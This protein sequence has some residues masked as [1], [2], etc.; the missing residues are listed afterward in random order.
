LYFYHL[1]CN[2]NISIFYF[3]LLTYNHS[4]M[5]DFLKKLIQAETTAEKGELAAAE[6]IS[7]EFGLSGINSRIDSWDQIRANIITRI[8]STGQRAGL[9]FACHLDVVGPGEAV[10]EH[11]AFSAV[12]TDGN[13]YGRGTVDMKG[14]TAAAVTAIRQIVDSGVQLKGDVVL[15]AV[16][17]EE[18]DSAGARRFVDDKDLMQELAPVG[19]AGVIIP[20][21]TD[22]EVITAH[23]GILWLQISTKG[24]AAHSSA[25]QLGVNAIG[26]MRLVLNELESYEIK[27]EPHEL[28]GMCS[29]SVNTI[30][31]GKAMNVVPDKC[32]VGI[33]FRTLPRQNHDQIVADLQGIFERLK[34]GDE[35]F[36]A[37]ISILR[38]VRPLETDVNSEFVK[39]FGSAVGINETKAINYTTDGP[40]FASIGAPIVIFGPGKPQ[41]CHKPD[42]Y[43]EISDLDKA[44]EYYKNI[45]LKFLS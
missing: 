36:D 18:T 1:I 30:A 24:K 17:G 5:K 2:K 27:A 25:P 42:E 44:V 10:W 32:C 39:I 35:N 22:F 6:V 9:L 28:L 33:D 31:G 3:V 12:E 14:G 16:A 19:L 13:I 26:S 8:E 41:L 43:I 11:P 45:I 38:Q 20:E 23:R 40:H 7:D 15:A 37:E 34:V 21:P 29:M 4:F